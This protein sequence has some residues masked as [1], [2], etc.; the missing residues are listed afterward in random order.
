V[1]V[2]YR[3]AADGASIASLATARNSTANETLM[4]SAHAARGGAGWDPA[5]EVHYLRTS[6]ILNPQGLV[7]YPRALGSTREN[8][9]PAPGAFDQLTSGLDVLDPA[10]CA[11]GNVDQPQDADPPSLADP[12]RQYA[13]RSDGRVVARPACVGQGSYPGFDTAFPQ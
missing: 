6:Q 10:L 7:Y 8:A 11:N 2:A 5:P 3:R 4:S 9:Y 1:S 13:Y 12:V